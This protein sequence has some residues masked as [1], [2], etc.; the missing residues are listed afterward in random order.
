MV[1][2]NGQARP[3][4][5]QCTVK[6]I[7]SHLISGH[8]STIIAVR[9]MLH[10]RFENTWRHMYGS[11]LYEGPLKVCWRICHCVIGVIVSSQQ[12]RNDHCAVPYALWTLNIY[13]FYSCMKM[14]QLWCIINHWLSAITRSMEKLLIEQAF[15]CNY[16]VN[17]STEHIRTA[18]ILSS[19]LLY[20]IRIIRNEV[21]FNHKQKSTIDIE[22]L[23]RHRV[24]WYKISDFIRLSTLSSFY[25][26]CYN[27]SKHYCYNIK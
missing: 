21:V 12:M 23:F 5:S 20:A 4:L 16:Y 8:T 27:S 6:T 11:P 19:E 24:C 17:W 10:I 3:I 14:K 9:R 15:F 25:I 22:R 1:Y 13:L 26:N 2:S 18:T 7:Y